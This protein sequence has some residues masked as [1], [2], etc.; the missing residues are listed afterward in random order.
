MAH[1]LL[2]LLDRS[3]DQRA[4]VHRVVTVVMF[5]SGMAFNARAGLKNL[6]RDDK[7]SFCLTAGTLCPANSRRN[8][9]QTTAPE[10]LHTTGLQGQGGSCRHQGRSN[11]GPAGGAV[12]RPP[13]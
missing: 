4:R 7:W 10:R 8:N 5:S 6:E 11:T 9:E 12:R 3:F 2:A 13:Q 1:A